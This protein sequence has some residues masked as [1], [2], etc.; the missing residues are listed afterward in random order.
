MTKDWFKEWF[1]TTYYHTLYKNRDEDEAMQFIDNL[2]THLKIEADSKILDLACGKGRHAMHLAKKGFRTT[3]VDLA[4]QSIFKAKENSNPKVQFAVH[5]MRK[6]FKK[7]EFNFVFNL[8]TSFGYFKNLDENIDVLNGVAKNLK[9][10]GLLVL[11]FLNAHKVIAN[12][13]PSEQKEIDGI[14]FKIKRNY[15]GKSIVKDIFV[16]DQDREFTFQE[17]VS[18]FNLK[19][20]NRMAESVGLEIIQTF[21]N[22]KLNPFKEK[23]SDRLILVMKLRD[24]N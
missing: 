21:G 8:F 10:D 14:Q 3:G 12:L 24:Y 22:Y 18:A 16:K 17:R 19:D 6:V 7:N 20:M 1:N 4:E 2:C 5:D 9:K 11:D 15:D 13:V 23:S